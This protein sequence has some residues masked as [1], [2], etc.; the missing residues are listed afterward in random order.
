[1][2]RDLPVAGPKVGSV[3]WPSK[4]KARVL[5]NNFPMEAMPDFARAKF[6]ASLK[7]GIQ[8]VKKD[9]RVSNTIEVE[10][11]DSLT[12]KVMQTVAE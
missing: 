6:L 7:H 11:V 9:N 2:V 8:T 3:Q 1:M 4:N 5:M 10:I 12:G